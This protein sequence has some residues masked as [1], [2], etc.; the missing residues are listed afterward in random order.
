M[1]MALFI[2]GITIWLI[3]WIKQLAEINAIMKK[4]ILNIQ[5]T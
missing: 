4:I 5:M 1:N 2:V 3:G